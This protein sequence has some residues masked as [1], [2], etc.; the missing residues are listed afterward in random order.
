MGCIEEDIYKAFTKKKDYTL[1]HF[2]N[3]EV[4]KM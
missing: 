4:S 1:K 2:Q 3:E